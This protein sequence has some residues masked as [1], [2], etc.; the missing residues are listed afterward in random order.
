MFKINE[1]I[2]QRSKVGKKTQKDYMK[3][4]ITRI[5]RSITVMIFALVAAFVCNS[6]VTATR[7]QDNKSYLQASRNEWNH[8]VNSWMEVAAWSFDDNALPKTFHVYSG[9]WQV[10]GGKLRSAAGGKVKIANCHW[11]A[12][13]LE[14]DVVLLAGKDV[15][16]NRIC[17]VGISFNA[18]S[19]TG[20]FRKGYAFITAQYYNQA[21]VLYRL[22]IPYARTEWS[23]IVP[24]RKHHV[25]VEVVKPHMRLWIDERVVLEGWER[26]G[27]TPRDYD[28]F[29]DMDPDKVITLHT[30]DTV[31]E[32][33]NLRILVPEKNL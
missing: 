11:P 15:S 3:L 18:D 32:I 24:G 23:P 28:D 2:L 8:H 33:D 25:M 5:I 21:T 31:M 30:Y 13:R 4:Q 19:K 17:D 14:F 1:I 22:N 20:S 12:F 10:T 26:K 9:E 7:G 6:C 16:S 29:M 27:M